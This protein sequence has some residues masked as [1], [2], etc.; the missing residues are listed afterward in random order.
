MLRRWTGEGQV[1]DMPRAAYEDPM[2]NARFSDRFIEDGSYLKL[3]MV[4][5]SYE[6]PVKPRFLQGITVWASC[7]NVW[8]W[9]NYLGLDPEVS[10]G[11]SVLYQGIDN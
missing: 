5:L 8:T 1:T 2:G 11:N 7:N 4:Q 10:C 6:L 3:K 9:T